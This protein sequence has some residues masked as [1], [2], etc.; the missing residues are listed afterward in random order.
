MED[1][2]E[3]KYKN[4]ELLQILT[5]NNRVEETSLDP[6]KYWIQLAGVVP[7]LS[8][9]DV[10]TKLNMHDKNFNIGTWRRIL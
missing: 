5:N 8:A 2:F 1:Q 3:S 7:Y 10:E 4:L 9:R 6:T